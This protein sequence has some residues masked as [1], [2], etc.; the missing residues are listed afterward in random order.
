MRFLI[1][2]SCS[3]SVSEALADAGHDVLVSRTAWAG[4]ADRVLADLAFEQGRVIVSEDFDFGDLAVRDKVPMIGVILVA[5]PNQ[6]T[7][8]RAARLLEVVADLGDRL[9]GAL[10]RVETRRIRQRPLG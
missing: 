5:C 2:E 10:T 3:R 9:L 6:T 7:H 1:D 8:E 4:A